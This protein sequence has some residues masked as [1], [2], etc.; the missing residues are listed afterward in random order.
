ME[1]VKTFIETIANSPHYSYGWLVLAVLSILPAI[2]SGN[3]IQQDLTK[4]I[5][6]TSEPNQIAKPLLFNTVILLICICIMAYAF[7]LYVWL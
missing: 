1:S 7:Y 4:L 2:V 3:L 6:N 5:K